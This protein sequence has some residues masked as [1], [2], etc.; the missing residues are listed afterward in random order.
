M[1][2]AFLL[3]GAPFPDPACAEPDGLLAVGGDLSPACLLAAYRQGIFPWYGEGM[4]VLWWSPHPRL[5]LEPRYVHVPRRLARVIR[6]ERF[7]ITADTAFA[8][9]IRHCATVP[10]PNGQG[11]W[12]VPAMET[13]YRRLHEL[14]YAHSIEVWREGRLVGGLYGVALG[15][16]FFGES[17]FHFEPDASKVGFVTLA[18]ALAQAGYT[19][20]DCQ[21]TTPHMVRLGGFEVSRE[22]FMRR[23]EKALQAP[24]HRGQW[25]LVEGELVCQFGVPVVQSFSIQTGGRGGHEHCTHT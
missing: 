21:Q 12:I 8:A 20:I 5:I 10:R 4:P 25:S 15:Q 6:N 16:V 18:R 23:L 13:A 11:T 1:A 7:K 14:G 19:L 22:E 17:M 3:P 2:V 24:T 9:V